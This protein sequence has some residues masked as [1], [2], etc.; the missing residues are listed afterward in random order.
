MYRGSWCI[1]CEHVVSWWL[2]VEA[3]FRS[4]INV[5]EGQ[6]LVIIFAPHPL[7]RLLLCWL[8][9]MWWLGGEFKA[10]IFSKFW[11]LTLLNRGPLS[12]NNSAGIL[13][14][15]FNYVISQ[16]KAKVTRFEFVSHDTVHKIILYA[17]NASCY[18]DLI[19]PLIFWLRKVPANLLQSLHVWSTHQPGKLHLSFHF[20]KSLDIVFSIFNQWVIYHL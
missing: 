7:E 16:P 20:W 6:V 2:L 14:C 5:Q 11:N 18:L 13:N 15:L 4:L 12:G 9:V 1:Y 8:W 19:P 10:V 3:S 17:S